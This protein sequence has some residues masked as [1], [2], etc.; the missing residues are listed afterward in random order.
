MMKRLKLLIYYCVISKL[1]HSRLFPPINRFRCWY[2]GRV[3]NVMS[4]EKPNAKFQNNVYL[5]SCINLSIGYGCHINENVFIQAAK[6][7]NYVLLAPNV[8]LLGNSHVHSDVSLPIVSQ[9][10][11]DIEPVVVCDGAWLG[12]N[13]IV[14]PGIKIGENAIVGAG[15]VVTN[16]IPDYAVAVGVPARI[17]KYRNEN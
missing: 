5:G 12:R 4:L 3:M 11:T 9:G 13:V 10:E 6:I 2:L 1:P 17:V 16:D 8:S 14:M 15:A 7:G